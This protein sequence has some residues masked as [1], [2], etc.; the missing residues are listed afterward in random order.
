MKVDQIG[1]FYDMLSSIS[2]KLAIM[3]AFLLAENMKTSFQ[4]SI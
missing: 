4:C 2:N 1:S 3:F